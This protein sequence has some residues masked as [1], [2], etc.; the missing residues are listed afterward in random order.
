MVWHYELISSSPLFLHIFSTTFHSGVRVSVCMYIDDFHTDCPNVYVSINNSP[1][2]YYINVTRTIN[3]P[4]TKMFFYQH[5]VVL[6]NLVHATKRTRPKQ[7]MNGVRTNHMTGS[8]VL[9]G[10]V[11][12]TTNN[13]NILFLSIE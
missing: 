13:S 9:V 7:L 11:N 2:Q 6:T 5:R 8:F 12:V 4:Q 1:S 3:Q 10:S